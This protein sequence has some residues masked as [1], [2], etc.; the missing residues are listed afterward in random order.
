MATLVGAVAAPMTARQLY[1][2]IASFRQCTKSNPARVILLA[3]PV[4]RFL[5]LADYFDVEVIPAELRRNPVDPGVPGFNDK[6]A[7]VASYK[8]RWDAIADALEPLD[9]TEP[10]LVT[11]TADVLFQRN[12]FGF[13]SD[14]VSVAGEGV[15]YKNDPWNRQYLT[16]YF[17]EHRAAL[18]TV[19]T[20]CAGVVA[21][22]AW[23]VQ[24]LACNIWDAIR[25][26]SGIADQTA[27][28]VVLRTQWDTADWR[29]VPYE[30]AWTCHC[31][32]LL[33]PWARDKERIQ[34]VPVLLSSGHVA[35]R[36]SKQTFAI[37]HHWPMVP[38]LAHFGK[39]E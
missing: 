38:E 28:N 8:Y 5:E 1:P 31:S 3:D 29:A 36:E 24:R 33:A 25:E 27:M 21:G 2:W 18:A 34:P 19:E 9:G 30:E 13:E 35:E 7:A 15:L 12:P 6:R 20:L 39:V 14:K 11:D 16:T 26:F 32:Q 4:E 23:L 37:V 22:P 10:V 17:P